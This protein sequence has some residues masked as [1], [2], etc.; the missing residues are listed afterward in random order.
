[1]HPQ[2]TAPDYPVEK[3]LLPPPLLY[4]SRLPFLSLSLS[5]SLRCTL[6]ITVYLR[7]ASGYTR[8]LSLYVTLFTAAGK[9]DEL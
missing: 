7:H 9:G 6:R 8:T 5:L 3:T 2:Q 1:M 4:S